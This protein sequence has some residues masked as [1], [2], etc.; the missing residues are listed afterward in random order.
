MIFLRNRTEG[1]ENVVA[2]RGTA[3]LSR[4]QAVVGGPDS[5][6]ASRVGNEKS[7]WPEEATGL[8]GVA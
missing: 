3:V 5:P 4:Q 1:R 7:D 8:A 2:W 6:E